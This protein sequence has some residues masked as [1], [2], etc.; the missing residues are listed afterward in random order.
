MPTKAPRLC[1]CGKVVTSGVRCTCQAGEDRDRKAR[2]DAKR[3]NS[4]ARGY[5][6]SWDKARAGYLKSHFYCVRCGAGATVVDH[7]KP[8]KGCKVLFWDKSNWQALCTP[9]HSG[10]KQSEERREIK[11]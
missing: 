5:T 1:R 7:K 8:H 11:R 2:F 10:A 4:S 9:C 6:G 3:P